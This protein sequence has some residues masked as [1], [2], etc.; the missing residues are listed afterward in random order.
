MFVHNAWFKIDIHN[1]AGGGQ[2]AGIAAAICA[3]R[4]CKPRELGVREVQQRLME[5]GVDL[6]LKNKLPDWSSKNR[7][8]DNTIKNRPSL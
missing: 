2:A 3:E 8:N 1:P 6:G 4:E 7:E 5:K